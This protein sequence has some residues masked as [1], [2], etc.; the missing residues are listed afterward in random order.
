MYVGHSAPAGAQHLQLPDGVSKAQ[1]HIA[2]SVSAAFPAERSP[3]PS[4][5]C[6]DWFPL[7]LP[8]ERQIVDKQKSCNTQIQKAARFYIRVPD[9]KEKYRQNAFLIYYDR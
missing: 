5:R 8:A 7:L 9:P 3:V 2:H 6:P 4:L 1:L